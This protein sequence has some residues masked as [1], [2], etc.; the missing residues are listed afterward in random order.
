MGR[1]A[2]DRHQARST[3]AGTSAHAPHTARQKKRENHRQTDEKQNGKST[4]PRKT[5]QKPQNPPIATPQVFDKRQLARTQLVHRRAGKTTSGVGTSRFT[6][7]KRGAERKRLRMEQ[8]PDPIHRNA[9]IAPSANGPNGLARL[10]PVST[11]KDT[12]RLFTLLRKSRENWIHHSKRET[13]LEEFR[14][15]GDGTFSFL[16]NSGDFPFGSV[17]YVEFLRLEIVNT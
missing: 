8:T 1:N 13:H 17:F 9:P 15:N 11:Q 7:N 4:S 2:N 12:F 14:N 10:H 16:R 3:E 6:A 5:T